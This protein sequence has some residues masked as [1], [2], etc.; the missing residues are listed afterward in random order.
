MAIIV[1]KGAKGDRF[2][3]VYRGTDGRQHVAG[4]FGTRREAE[5]AYTKAKARVALGIDARPKKPIGLYKYDTKRGITLA[6][7]ADVWLPSHPLGAHARETY[8]AI[9][10]AKIL[11]EL[12]STALADI[13]VPT[14]KALFRKMEAAG[15]SNAY[16]SKVK[17]VLSAMMQAAAEDADIPG[18]THN[19]VRGIR[20]NGIRPERRQA[21]SK[22]DFAKLL[23]EVPEHY[24]L[25]LRTIAGSGIRV[26]EAMGL[27]DDDLVVTDAGCWLLVRHVLVEVRYPLTHTLRDGTKNGSTRKVMIDPRLASELAALPKGFMFLRPDG[28]HISL[29][30]FRKLVWRPAVKR[31]GLPATFAFRDLRRCHATW[32]KAGQSAG[33]RV[34][35]EAIRDR[36]GHSSVTITDRYL[37]A[38]ADTGQAALD[39]LGDIP[40]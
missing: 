9:L 35:L 37:A 19:P 23:A 28:R 39:A 14:V 32:L 7:Y 3:A 40:A 12:S 6:T 25:L 5:K 38:P 8:Q 17:T 1:I 21:I 11:P 4:T 33:G 29:D 24:R 20:V 13:D 18:V 27:R 30:S 16:L 31:A 10:R 15:A 22:P 36:L 34:D 26:E 2:K